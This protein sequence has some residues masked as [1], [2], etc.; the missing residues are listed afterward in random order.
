MKFKLFEQTRRDFLSKLGKAAIGAMAPK[1]IVNAANVAPSYV[2]KFINSPNVGHVDLDKFILFLKHTYVPR[3]VVEYGED[4]GDYRITALKSLVSSF[5]KF[6][7]TGVIDDV[8]DEYLLYSDIFDEAGAL[9]WG[10]FCDEGFDKPVQ[11]I[12]SGNIPIR[13]KEYTDPITGKVHK[14]SDVYMDQETFD[15][16]K[17]QQEQYYKD[18]EERNRRE[19]EAR[20]K[21]R[22]S[23]QDKITITLPASVVKLL[24]QSLTTQLRK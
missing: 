23:S 11:F 12:K 8:V 5:T 24:I 7:N 6:R 2:P 20:K 1:S 17:Q 13:I 19:A 4:D 14:N 21:L 16:E 15:I 18:N 3:Q 10:C 9:D 22:Q